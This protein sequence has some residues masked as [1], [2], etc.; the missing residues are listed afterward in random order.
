MTER[1]RCRMQ[2]LTKSLSS[3]AWDMT[4][5]GM[6]QTLNVFGLG[7]PGS[8]NRATD[9]LENVTQAT[10]K[11][12]SD[13]MRAV[14]KSGDSLQRGMVDLLFAPARLGNW[15]ERRPDPARD[16]ASPAGDGGAAASR[17]TRSSGDRSTGWGPI[18]R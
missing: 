11:E 17:S 10:T 6:Q 12:V 2:D 3:F 5:F 1:A 9:A 13:S 15:A 14:F 7:Q 16:A 8:W 4:V 18:P